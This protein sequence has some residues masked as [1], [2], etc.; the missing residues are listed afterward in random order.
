MTD[1]G[2]IRRSGEVK[3]RCARCGAR[4]AQHVKPKH[5][6]CEDCLYAPDSS[7]DERYLNA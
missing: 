6:W 5:Q 3:Q 4:F 2:T 1:N 7:R